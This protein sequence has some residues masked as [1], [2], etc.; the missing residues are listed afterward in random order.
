MEPKT[1]TGKTAS[2]A[3]YQCRKWGFENAVRVVQMH[4]T[5]TLPLAMQSVTRGAKVEHPEAF[6]VRLDYEK[7]VGELMPSSAGRALVG[8]RKL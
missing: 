6:A 4:P 8:K 3:E 5:E 1:F 2:D 7:H